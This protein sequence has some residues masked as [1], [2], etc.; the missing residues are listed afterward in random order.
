MPV[1]WELGS[2]EKTNSLIGV[3][4]NFLNYLL[5]HDVCPEYKE[6]INNTRALCDQGVK[7]LWSVWQA[8][9][10]LPGDFNKACSEIFGGMYRGL[11][12]ENRKW[13]DDE[14]IEFSMGI[15]P[16]VARKTFKIALAANATE[17]VFESYKSQPHDRTNCV[18]NREDVRI[19]ITEIVFANKEVLTLYAQPQCAGLKPLGKMKAKTWHIPGETYEDL[20]EEEEA[21]LAATPPETKE[22]EFWVE[23]QLLQ[24]CFEGMKLHVT[25][26]HLSF[27]ISYFDAVFGVYCSFH[28][29]LPNALI[30]NWREPEKE[31]L[32]MRKKAGEALM[33]QMDEPVEYE[34]Q[35]A[36][37]DEAE[38]DD[39]WDGGADESSAAKPEK[40][41]KEDTTTTE[42]TR[43]EGE[44]SSQ[45]GETVGDQ[46]KKTT[47][48]VEEALEQV[49]AAEGTRALTEEAGDEAT[50][51]DKART[52]F[53][54][55]STVKVTKAMEEKVKVQR[56]DGKVDEIPVQSFNVELREPKDEKTD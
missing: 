13:M 48:E 7:E 46:D 6:Q 44:Q 37:A 30:M 42:F 9:H 31:W 50:M 8:Q 56:L 34:D 32:P 23:D 17:E 41:A 28:R 11:Y 16:E 51:N 36:G 55:G 35:Q 53:E 24:K 29:V 15:S 40:T 2:E 45:F 1:Q 43:E 39:N 20:T 21:A 22:Y 38:V 26:S 47:D 19:E 18:A 27:G 12:T 49:S 25:A 4:R 3:I 52:V 33:D 14:D 54:E 5:Y 10:F